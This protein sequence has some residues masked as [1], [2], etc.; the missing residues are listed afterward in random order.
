MPQNPV[1]QDHEQKDT[2]A[3]DVIE[4]GHDPR[5][6]ASPLF[7]R[8]RLALL[9]REHGRCWLSGMTAEES[10]HPLEAHHHPVER[11]FT[12]RWDWPRFAADCKAGEWGVHAQAFDWDGF[13]AGSTTIIANDTGKPYVKV[14]DPYLFVDN[15]LVNGRLLAKQ[16][17]TTPNEGIHNLDGPRFLAEKYLAE[18][19]KFSS[20]EVIHHEQE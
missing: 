20:I 12:E 3:I 15:M 5:G 18:G 1:T 2:L 9:E 4:P 17:H 6:G 8:T 10:G 19:F 14:R 13:F 11:C 7:K 16:F